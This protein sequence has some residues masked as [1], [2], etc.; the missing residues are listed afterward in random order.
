VKI[1]AELAEKSE[2]ILPVVSTS[3]INQSKDVSTPAI[4]SSKVT[5]KIP[6]TMTAHDMNSKNDSSIHHD[7]LDKHGLTS[8]IDVSKVRIEN[9]G[10]TIL[11]DDIYN[12]DDNEIESNIDSK[13]IESS[14]LQDDIYNHDDG[15][16][17]VYIY[18]SLSIY[19]YIYIYV[20]I[21]IYIYIYICIYIY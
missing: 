4:T 16:E 8:D 7:L 6:T 18:I 13:D 1:T 9:E 2:L 15:P 19:I 5:L 11:Q 20:Y 21:Y 3:I 10:K 17:E 12:H 14:I